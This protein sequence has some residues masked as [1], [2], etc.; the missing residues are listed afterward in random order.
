MKKMFRLLEN[1]K[2]YN[3]FCEVN[4]FEHVN[5]N[6]TDL[7]I[8]LIQKQATSCAECD[9]L[10]YIPAADATMQFKFDSLDQ[11][12]VIERAG[13]MAFPT[14]DRSIWKVTLLAGDKING[15]VKVTLTQ[16]GQTE[17]I[18]L[19]GRLVAS[20]TDSERFFC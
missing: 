2:D 3:T 17:T 15:A 11:A 18:L 14:E 8:R 13:T 4:T 5:G 20:G 12:N 1:V 7:Y 9:H 16:N 6:Q 19:D 10:R